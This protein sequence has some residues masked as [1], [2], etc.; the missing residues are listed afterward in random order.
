MEIASGLVVFIVLWWIV[1]F[2]TLPIGVRPPHETGG[3]IIPGQ[4]VGAPVRPRLVL[5]AAV[6]TLVAAVLWAGMYWLITSDL[7]SFR[8]S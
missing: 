3:N 8:Q 5:K 2:T 4:E 1:F 7:S 6:T